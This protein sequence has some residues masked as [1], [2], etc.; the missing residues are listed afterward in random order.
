M[1]KADKNVWVAA[2]RSGNYKQG[3]GELH[4]EE[5]NSYCCLGVLNHLFPKTYPASCGEETLMETKHF[6][7][8][9]GTIQRYDDAEEETLADINDS[10]TS[11][12]QIAD[13]IDQYY[14]EL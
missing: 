3:A 1:D 5:T 11:F 12:K 6:K 14:Q 7:T 10:G 9:E 13:L 2:L 4:N 8:N